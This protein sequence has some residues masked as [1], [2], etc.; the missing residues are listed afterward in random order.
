MERLQAAIEKARKQREA[1]G[2]GDLRREDA[3]GEAPG[4]LGARRAAAAADTDTAAARDR[5]SVV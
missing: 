5:K 1:T 3:L 2:Q 4:A